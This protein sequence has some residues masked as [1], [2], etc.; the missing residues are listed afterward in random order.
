MRKLLYILAFAGSAMI[1]SCSVYK[2]NVAA[3]QTLETNTKAENIQTD[4]TVSEAPQECV[5]KSKEIIAYIL[6][7]K[8]D[9][10]DDKEAQSRWLSESLR[11][12]LVYRQDAYTYHKKSIADVSDNVLDVPH[13]EQPPGNGDFVGAWDYPTTYKIEGSRRYGERIVVDV[14]FIWGKGTQ[15]EGDTRLNSYIFKLEDNTCKLN[16]IYIFEGEFIPAS[17]LSQKLR[18]PNF[19]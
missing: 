19:H 8:P 5:T 15:Y 17:S 14:T 6:R 16:D 10:G 13:P 12:L 11:K 1:Q 18:D 4:S 9:I 7:K 3:Q 2:E